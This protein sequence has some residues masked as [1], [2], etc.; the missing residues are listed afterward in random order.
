MYSCVT[1]IDI[2]LKF[3]I[4]FHQAERIALLRFMFVNFRL[5][6]MVR[7]MIEEIVALGRHIM[8]DY[9]G[10]IN[11]NYILQLFPSA[12]GDHCCIFRTE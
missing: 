12:I 7:E 5:L 9:R 11:I 2:Y 6:L 8:H 1:V 3:K 4:S 10:N